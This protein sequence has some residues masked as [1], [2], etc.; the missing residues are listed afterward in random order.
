[1]AYVVFF[2]DP[3]CHE[4]SYKLVMTF[5]TRFTKFC[6]VFIFVRNVLELKLPNIGL[7]STL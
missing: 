3:N 5:I 7:L 1:M 4:K 2:N 6:I